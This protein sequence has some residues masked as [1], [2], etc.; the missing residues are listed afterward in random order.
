MAAALFEGEV[1]VFVAVVDALGRVAADALGEEVGEVGDGDALGGFAA[2][3]D[4]GLV[5]DLRPLETDLVAV[6]VERL[7]VL[8]GGL[9]E[10]AGD[11][12]ADVGVAEA[13]VGAF[14]GEGRAVL[15][16]PNAS[17]RSRNETGLTNSP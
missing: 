6:D 17:T 4:G 11:L 5:L 3:E 2:V 13:D 7:A 16:R 15:L 1:D 10:R 14:Q 12:G 8:A 9:E